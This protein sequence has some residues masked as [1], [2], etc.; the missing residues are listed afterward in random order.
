MWL[1]ILDPLMR[2]SPAKLY[3]VGAFVAF[4]GTG[5]VIFGGSEVHRV[6]KTKSWPAADGVL[7]ICQ[8]QDVSGSRRGPSFRLRIAYHFEVAGKPFHGDRLTPLGAPHE[9]ERDATKRALTHPP[10]RPCRV[11]YNPADPKENCLEPGATG[12]A[13]MWVCMG[14]VMLVLGS[15]PLVS[16]FWIPAP[17]N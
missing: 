15:L 14:V 5:L 2:Q 4:A 9:S 13:W 8:V 10:G 3:I 12:R 16:L 7:D 6:S 17:K 1:G 11:F